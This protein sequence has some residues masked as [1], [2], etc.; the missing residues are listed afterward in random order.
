MTV[1]RA[2]NPQCVDTPMSDKD[3]P[4]TDQLEDYMKYPFD[5]DETYKESRILIS[6][7]HC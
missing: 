3:A 4:P 2:C 5:S 7:F 6:I 1:K